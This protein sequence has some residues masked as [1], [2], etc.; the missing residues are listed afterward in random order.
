MKREERGL[1]SVYSLATYLGDGWY[2]VTVN[3][4]DPEKAPRG[5]CVAVT[6]SAAK[7]AKAARGYGSKVTAKQVREAMK[8]C[9]PQS[10]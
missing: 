10:K 8:A 4:A 9:T 6:K 3:D 2:R 5:R 7:F 1:E